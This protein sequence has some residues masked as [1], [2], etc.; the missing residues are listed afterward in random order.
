AKQVYH[1][2]AVGTGNTTKML[3]N[4]IKDINLAGTMEGLVAGAALGVDMDAFFEV[5]LNAS[6]GSRQ[7]ERVA[8]AVLARDFTPTAVTKG[9]SRTQ[10]SMKQL[11]ESAGAPTPMF[12]TARQLWLQAIEQGLGELSSSEAVRVLEKQAGVEVKGR[13]AE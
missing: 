3:N 1:M 5:V 13:A 9:L 2:G 8:P 4:L 10:K 11:M 6:G 7:W 12:D